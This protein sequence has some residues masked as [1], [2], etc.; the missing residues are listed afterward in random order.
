MNDV[1]TIS[2]TIR[3]YKYV[4][5]HVVRMNLCAE[6]LM[7]LFIIVVVGNVHH[8]TSLTPSGGVEGLLAQIDVE[9]G[10]LSLCTSFGGRSSI[11]GSSARAAIPLTDRMRLPLCGC[12]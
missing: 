11:I 9:L 4:S 12:L 8:L 6:L 2:C 1:C 5:M 10:A 3:K 7:T